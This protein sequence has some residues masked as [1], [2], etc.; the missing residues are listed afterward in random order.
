MC[1]SC[2]WCQWINNGILSFFNVPYVFLKKKIYI[3]DNKKAFSDGDCD[4]KLSQE[5][6]ILPL[7]PHVTLEGPSVPQVAHVD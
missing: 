4:I 1:D 3:S 2:C 6:T 5:N 7:N